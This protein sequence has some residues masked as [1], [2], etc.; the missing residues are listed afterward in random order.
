MD[1]LIVLLLA[2]TIA[3]EFVSYKNYKVYRVKPTSK[4]QL[5]V[6]QMFKN[7]T[8]VDFWTPVYQES[9]EPVNIMV[10]PNFQ[11]EFQQTLSNHEIEYDITVDNAEE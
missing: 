3:G 7:N 4:E 6:L 1:L 9:L 8:D 11:S 5:R 10:S 2:I